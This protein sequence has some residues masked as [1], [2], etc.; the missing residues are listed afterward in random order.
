M[1]KKDNGLSPE[2]LA[3]WM[4]LRQKTLDRNKSLRSSN[5]TGTFEK[6]QQTGDSSALRLWI[7]KEPG[8]FPLHWHTCAEIIMVIEGTY[9]V[10]SNRVSYTL[11]AGDIIVVPPGELHELRPNSVGFRMIVQFDLNAMSKFRGFTRLFSVMPH[12]ILITA[13]NL[14]E[15]HRQERELLNN[16]AL[17]YSGADTLAD[18]SAAACMI[19]FFVLLARCDQLTQSAPSP[20]TQHNKQKEYVE[21]FNAV[22]DYIERN[23]A[24]N[25]TLEDVAASIGFSKFHFSRLFRT[26]TD[27]SFY[28]YLC[29]RRLKAA[30]TLLLTPDLPITEVALQSGFSSISTFNRVFKKYKECTPSEFKEFYSLPYN[31]TRSRTQAQINNLATGSAANQPKS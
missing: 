23:Y 2:E 27:T 18:A 1:T 16:T 8:N 6:F 11:N 7:N 14:P 3:Y 26:Y 24:E 25:I 17:E 13:E 12:A 21:K 10:V 20:N 31:S 28:D 30:E 5:L 22:F 19:R 29:L 4:D 15:L 9:T